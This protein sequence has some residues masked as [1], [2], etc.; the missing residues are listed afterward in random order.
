MF[1]IDC[2]TGCEVV[3]IA[4]KDK[5]VELK[6]RATGEVTTES[7]DKLVL[8]PGA[9]RSA[10]RCRGST[11]RASSRCGRCR[12]PRRMR[13]WVERSLAEP[14]GLDSYTGS[15]ARRRQRRAVVVGGGFIGLEMAENLIELGLDVTVVQRGDQL[16]APRRSGDGALRRA[17]PGEPRR[18]HPAERRRVRVRAGRRTGRSRCSTTSGRT[19][20]ADVVVLGIGVRPETELAEMAGVELGERG[21]IQRR[22]PDAHERPGH[23]RRRRR[24]REVGLHDRRVDA[25]R[26]RRA[27][28]PAGPHRGRRDRR[29]RRAVPRHA[30]HGDRRPVRRRARVDRRQREDAP[31]ARRRGLREGLP[32]PELA[33]RVLPRR[34]ADRDEGASSASP[35]AASSGRRPSAGTAWTSASTRWPWPSSWAARSTTWRRPSCATRRSSAAPSRR[36][37]SPA[38]SPPTCWAATCPSR[39]GAPW[40]ASSCWTCGT[41]RS[42]PRRRCPASS[43]SRWTSCA[44]RLDEL[45]RDRDI[46]VICRSGQRAYYATRIL[47]QNGFDAR[48]VSGGMLSHEIFSEV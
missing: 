43:T 31:A 7:Y 38:W 42:S 24:G 10:R 48:V 44:S 14:P 20:P 11:C 39:T 29:A 25:G 35:T 26:A 23:L 19:L 36:P 37:T 13:E 33:R 2:R 1:A 28:E 46:V 4:A 47:V 18:P 45:P 32:L 9:R 17:A 12:T 3:G 16:M 15:Q 8:S 6:D 40:T 41:P 21:G 34:R 30:G 27:G 5:T 22:R